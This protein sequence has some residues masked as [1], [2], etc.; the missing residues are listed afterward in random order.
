MPKQVWKIDKFE[1]GINNKSDARDILDSQLVQADGIEVNN[2]GK[3]VVGGGPQAV[4]TSGS[5]PP[6]DVGTWDP[7]GNGSLPG[8]TQGYGLVKFGTDYSSTA[9][10]AETKYLGFFDTANNDLSILTTTSNRLHLG[11]TACSE[12]SN[13]ST[14]I[15]T[16]AT[17]P[18]KAVFYYADGALRIC[19]AN[20]ANANP[21]NKWIGVIK[22]TLF[23][24]LP[25]DDGT[26]G[27][28]A[29]VVVSGWVTT[30]QE[31][32]S[33]GDTLMGP[34]HNHSQS[35]NSGHSDREK[36][37][38]HIMEPMK[39][40]YI[41]GQ[42]GW[43]GSTPGADSISAQKAMNAH[44]WNGC[45]HWDSLSGS[46]YLPN[47]SFG[48]EGDFPGTLTATS[49]NQSQYWP[50]YD[51]FTAGADYRLP[52]QYK[53]DTTEGSDFGLSTPSSVFISMT[54]A[55]GVG[56]GAN[57][58]FIT[59]TGL[60]RIGFRTY[61]I[62]AGSTTTVSIGV[63]FNQSL[64]NFY[65]AHQGE[66]NK[67][68]R[69]SSFWFDNT[70][71]GYI[72]LRNF[73][74]IT[75]L[76]GMSPPM[77]AG[78][79]ENRTFDGFKITL[80]Y[81]DAGAYNT[82]LDPTPMWSWSFSPADFYIPVSQGKHFVIELN[83]ASS[84]IQVNGE[85]NCMTFDFTFS[86]I[87]EE[88]NSGILLTVSD[89]MI[90]NPGCAMNE[91]G[92][93][94]GNYNFGL[95]NIIEGGSESSV[96]D[97]SSETILPSARYFQKYQQ[98]AIIAAWSLREAANVD[99][100]NGGTTSWHNNISSWGVDERIKGQNLY[101]Q[102][103]DSDNWF[104]VAELNLGSD[105]LNK[106]GLDES[107]GK[108][109]IDTPWKNGNFNSSSETY[110]NVWNTTYSTGIYSNTLVIK[111][112]SLIWEYSSLNAFA[113]T[114][115]SIA[116]RFKTAIQMNRQIYIGG[117]KQ[118]GI[119]Y[120]DRMIKSPVNKFDVF[121]S[122]GR[123]IDVIVKDGDHVTVVEGFADRILQFKK[124]AVN[125]INCTK[126]SEFLETT[127][128]NIGVES[129]CHVIKTDIGIA[130][131][132]DRGCYLYDGE[133]FT[134]LIDGKID[135]STGGIW[136]THITLS[137]LIGY[138]QKGRKILV[139]GGT[140]NK[141]V[142]MFSLQT[143]G[144]VKMPGIFTG[145]SAYLQTNLVT[146][147]D[148][149]VYWV[150]KDAGNAYVWQ[151]KISQ[152][153]TIITKDMDFGHPAVKK[154]MSKVYVT[155]SCTTAGTIA[156]TYDV[157]GGSAL[158]KGFTPITDFADGGGVAE[159]KPDTSLEANNKNS[160]Q[161]KLTGTGHSEDFEINDISIIYRIKNVK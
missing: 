118:Q 120:S 84:S 61:A 89:F 8:I 20:F 50:L 24:E 156:L 106:G 55:Y 112:A 3:I 5:S 66:H 138:Q 94:S 107:L 57:S 26:G 71:S 122:K 113:D 10:D 141:D 60:G 11:E 30:N 145:T 111:D 97:R 56:E 29:P 131:I 142:Y 21:S 17:A 40:F 28:A 88:T 23:G 117:L 12:W 124:N 92:F 25:I 15:I 32:P 157:N 130:F 153:F 19:D 42:S 148:G 7:N 136:D 146:F 149:Q 110:G 109:S 139:T 48:F 67:G 59:P 75:N 95:T 72:A 27:N 114:S 33:A 127:I 1:G 132:N 91:S 65:K 151:D 133:K 43:D 85:I 115:T 135:D 104:R 18:Q 155:Y 44:I 123:E 87:T 154:K 159:L 70:K 45:F 36:A 37:A 76:N 81:D 98:T 74:G 38:W 39:Y 13:L 41:D 121:P 160:F 79:D 69:T 134:N 129:P 126:D 31:P 54:N 93:S 158:D 14:D 34:S 68:G 49:G 63:Q 22:K 128:Q 152:D 103:T 140:N 82:P 47:P 6:T 147:F 16:D 125:V 80:G 102:R 144:W 53:L 99:E 9:T 78:T 105:S 90:G 96:S 77:W 73:P 108:F 51:G 119:S 64:M 35:S 161:L 4:Y 101:I 46:S 100:A 143:G 52:F 116:A 83:P 86:S 62:P 137:S 2:V 58:S 150:D